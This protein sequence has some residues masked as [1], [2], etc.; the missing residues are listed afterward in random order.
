METPVA[1]AE[2]LAERIRAGD[3][4]AA[5]EFVS[6][7]YRR[8]LI[9]AR[10]R[11]R[12]EHLAMRVAMSATVE[13]LRRLRDRNELSQQTL[14]SEVLCEA[15][16]VVDDLAAEADDRAESSR[17]PLRQTTVPDLVTRE[18]EHEARVRQ[19]LDAAR[20]VDRAILGMSLV[21]GMGT[22]EIGGRLGMRPERVRR[23]K[24]RAVKRLRIAVQPLTRVGSMDGG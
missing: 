13:V 10:I 24:S 22:A 2:N 14:A 20:P 17:E 8:I 18:F 16:R 23:R 15:R 5:L 7:F 9:M 4:V 11:L 21:E 12:D 19:I 3:R 6:R 1:T